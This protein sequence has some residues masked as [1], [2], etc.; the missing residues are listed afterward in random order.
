MEKQEKSNKKSNNKLK[1]LHNSLMHIEEYK[2]L[3]DF[4]IKEFEKNNEIHNFEGYILDIYEEIQNATYEY[5]DKLRNITQ[6]LKPDTKTNEGKTQKIIYDILTDISKI[7]DKSMTEFSN[8]KDSETYEEY[9]NA[10]YES[11]ND[12]DEKIKL[13]DEKRRAYFEEIQKYE[14]YLIKKEL[15][16]L[17]NNNEN[18][19]NK[20][21]KKKKD[22]GKILNDNFKEVKELQEKYMLF[23]EDIIKIIRSIFFYLNTERKFIYHTIKENCFLLVKSIK[24]CL[25]KLI[26]ICQKPVDF[27]N[28]NSLE[29]NENIVE[30]DIINNIIEENIYT[31][32]YTFKFLNIK[33]NENIEED[34]KHRKKKKDESEID[35]LLEKLTEE[36]INN[37]INVIKEHDIK[38]SK[39]NNDKVEIMFENKLYIEST[40]LS[41]MNDPDNFDEKTKNSIIS[42]FGKNVENQYS[43]MR[44]LNNYRAKGTFSFKKKTI[45]IFSDLFIFI[46]D[47]A[48]KNND[49]KMIQFIMI[50]SLTYYYIDENTTNGNPDN[51]NTIQ[52][53]DQSKIFITNYLRK[54]DII[55]EKQYW[56]TYLNALLEEENEKKYKRKEKT[57]NE[58][59]KSV[60]IYS[61]IFTLVKNI[62]DY[63]L[64]FDFINNILEDI[65]TLYKIKDKEKKDITDYLMLEIRQKEEKKKKQ[66]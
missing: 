15:G 38:F 17:E 24:N 7:L 65:F 3:K 54:S 49:H 58:K 63:E 64:D 50:L 4:I 62:V 60:A 66:K 16:M 35:G 19:I 6:K 11:N 18:D 40:I 5:T 30:E 13:F 21:D 47:S 59:Q 31:P 29:V 22:K 8:Q 46:L 53:E 34:K 57:V 32:L 2:K 39:E 25:E 14:L 51:Q 37:I 52:D 55:K 61:S 12:F 42:L 45:E 23:K 28:S 56:L 9:K 36:N 48:V 1:L 27:I 26:N 10:F 41:I 33:K 43:F 44:Y 20:K